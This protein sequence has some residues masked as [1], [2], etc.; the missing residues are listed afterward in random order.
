MMILNHQDLPDVPHGPASLINPAK[1]P[2]NL[3]LGGGG[4]PIPPAQV[5]LTSCP[6]LEQDLLQDE[7]LLQ[8]VQP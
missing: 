7:E 3:I 5:S 1:K 4:V 2:Q 6:H 8:M